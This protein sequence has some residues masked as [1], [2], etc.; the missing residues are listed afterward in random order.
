MKIGWISNI[1]NNVR[2][3]TSA[4][5]DVARPPKKASVAS[6]PASFE[7]TK[8]PTAKTSKAVP[9]PPPE[10]INLD[11]AQIIRWY[12]GDP[13]WSARRI[14]RHLHVSHHTILARVREFESGEK[15]IKD[16]QRAECDANARQAAANVPPI[17]AETAA[18]PKP[19][20]PTPV[21]TVQSSAKTVTR[22]VPGPELPSWP[23]NDDGSSNRAGTWTAREPLPPQVTY[24]HW[25]PGRSEGAG[26]LAGQGGAEE[27]WK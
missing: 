26:G 7:S 11:V 12:R 2:G 1:L 22:T 21:L 25:M 20:P 3:K 24:D 5:T 14:A 17:P 15:T 16:R 27:N 19:V 13:G 9:P 18:K 6:K 23:P 10:R 8:P 4:V